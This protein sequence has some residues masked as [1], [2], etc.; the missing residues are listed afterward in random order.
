MLLTLVGGNDKRNFSLLRSPSLGVNAPLL[1]L[2]VAV[3]SRLSSCESRK[4]PRPYCAVLQMLNI[5][6]RLF[7]P[8]AL[9]ELGERF[10]G[11]LEFDPGVPVLPHC[12]DHTGRS[13]QFLHVTNVI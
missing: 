7:E 10:V 9:L 6:K 11:F 12:L 13:V 2:V 1:N 3:N 4:Y 5:R 8:E